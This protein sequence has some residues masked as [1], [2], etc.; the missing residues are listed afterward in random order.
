MNWIKQNIACIL[1]VPQ[2]RYFFLLSK[3]I[4]VLIDGDSII[5]CRIFHDNSKF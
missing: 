4:N 5:S 2:S 1:I 3:S